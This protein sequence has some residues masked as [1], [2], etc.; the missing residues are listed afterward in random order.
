MQE[1]Y[2]I[3][4]VDIR[5]SAARSLLLVWYDVS[6]FMAREDGDWR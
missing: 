6:V 5:D 2:V 3:C 4:E 1:L